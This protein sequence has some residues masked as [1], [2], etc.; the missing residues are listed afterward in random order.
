MIR[1]LAFLAGL[2]IASMARAETYAFPSPMPKASALKIEASGDIEA[3]EPLIRDFQSLNPTIAITYVDTLT[4]DLFTRVSEACARG[5][6]IADLV[7]SSSVD[8]MV[9]LA[10]DGC[11]AP[12]TSTDTAR[13]PAHARWRDEVFGFTFEPAVIV[14]NRDLVPASEIP[15]TRDQLADLLR[16]QGAKYNGRIGTYDIARSGIGYL[17]AFFDAQQ[18]STFGRL[19]E[20]FGRAEAKLFCCTG[21]L[22]QEIEA[23]RI[24]IG[25][26]LL[27]S[28]AYGRLR[29]GA[30]IGIVMPRDYTLVLSRAA[31]IP[32][33]APNPDAG[34]AF[35]DYLLSLR[36]QKIAAERSFF[37]AQS[38]PAPDGVDAADPVT[39]AGI[40][41]PIPIGPALLAVSDRQKRQRIL[42]DWKQSLGGN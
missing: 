40:N 11:A 13:A 28:Y 29:A 1:V 8:H 14:Y 19:I 7:F 39:Q 27:G 42:N 38:E 25:Y 24:L 30:P 4:N 12:H 15:R 6:P 23:G 16:N 36:G 17:F 37:F 41:R 10:N 33:N 22:L 35:L 9:K 21:E 20:T 18:S 26:N 2:C 34:K 3:I 5:E 32:L 31:F